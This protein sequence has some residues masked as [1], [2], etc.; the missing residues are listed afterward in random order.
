VTL[1]FLVWQPSGERADDWIE[2]Y[3]LAV[4]I[5]SLALQIVKKVPK[6]SMNQDVCASLSCTDHALRCFASS[7]CW[8]IIMLY[9]LVECLDCVQ[10]MWGVILFLMVFGIAIRVFFVGVVCVDMAKEHLSKSEERESAEQPAELDADAAAA[11]AAQSPPPVSSIAADAQ[12][13]EVDASE[14]LDAAINQSVARRAPRSLAPSLRGSLPPSLSPWYDAC[15]ENE[16]R[17]Q[18]NPSEDG[19]CPQGPGEVRQVR[20]GGERRS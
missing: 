20:R 2:S 18:H 12:A 8:C 7:L 5:V 4:Q 6:Y 14:S 16:P 15:T 1:G 10:A 19:V 17:H 13:E 9:D 11:A 3:F